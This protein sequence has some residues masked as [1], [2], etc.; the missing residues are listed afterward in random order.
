[1]MKQ[2]WSSFM[3]RRVKERLVGATILVVLIV[4]IVPELLSG[5]THPMTVTHPSQSGAETTRNVTVDLATSKATPAEVPASAAASGAGAT[6][7]MPGPTSDV[8][9]PGG[10][11]GVP[12]GVPYGVPDPHA[13]AGGI[14]ASNESPPSQAAR[15]VAPPSVTTLQAQQSG[16]ANVENEAPPPRS[17]V[18]AQKSSGAR[19]AGSTDSAHHNWAVQLGSFASRTNA[20]KLEHRLK[21]EGFAA[22][23]SQAGAGSSLR[24]RVR[25]GPMADRAGA[26]RII[27]RLRKDGRSAGVVTPSIVTPGAT[28]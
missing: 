28:P 4:L 26:E 9:P 8:T 12:S 24:Y 3:E 1:M 21:S 27:A 15:G 14:A 2:G 6:P 13:A 11:N 19:E 20:D 5:P 25:V 10:P 18:P 17:A 7:G 23:V 16:T 22:F